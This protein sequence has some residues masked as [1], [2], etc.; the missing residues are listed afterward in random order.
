MRILLLSDTHGQLHPSIARLAARCEAIV[1]A[2]DVGHPAVLQQL[3]CNG[4]PVHAVRGNN[5]TAAKWP[6]S[7]HAALAQLAPLEQV[8]LPGGDLVVVHGDRHNPAAQRH[9]LLRAS[10]P[11]ARLV[12]YGHSHR[13]VIDKSTRPWIVNPGAA[14]RSRTY[15]GAGCVVLSAKPL[16]WTLRAYQFALSKSNT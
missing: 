12:V 6:S 3:M 4:I 14:G 9:A 8:G 11:Q 10:Y 1:H 16:R 5:D 2:G 7:A 15:G 13:Q